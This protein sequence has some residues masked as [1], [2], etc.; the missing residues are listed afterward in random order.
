MPQK[1]SI[2]WCDRSSNPIAFR[3]K[4]NGK[5]GWHCVHHSTGCLHCYSEGLNMRFGTKLPFHKSSTE[6]VEPFV[7]E[8]EL[9]KLTHLKPCKVFLCD[10]TDLF[11]DFIP[12]EMLCR[13]FEAINEAKAGTVFQVLTKRPENAARFFALYPEHANLL[14]VWLGVSVE[15]QETAD[16]RIPELL[17]IPAAV[18]F[19]SVEP[20]LGPI[21]L[22]RWLATG[23]IHWVIVGGESG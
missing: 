19:L 2:E 9:A 1:T 10:M 18:R 17:K 14:N 16:K 13:V 8:D 15:N 7:V 22:T 11:G 3:R 23:G 12:D 21:D 4:D 20:L 5:R 6:L